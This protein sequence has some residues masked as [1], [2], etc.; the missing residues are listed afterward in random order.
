MPSLHISSLIRPQRTNSPEHPG[1]KLGNTGSP[2]SAPMPSYAMYGNTSTPAIPMDQIPALNPPAAIPTQGFFF[3]REDVEEDND[4]NNNFK[5][6]SDW[7]VSRILAYDRVRE[8]RLYDEAMYSLRVIR[9]FI[10][11]TVPVGWVTYQGVFGR[12]PLGLL[13]S[14]SERVAVSRVNRRNWVMQGA[15]GRAGGGGGSGGSA[16]F[17]AGIGTVGAAA[18]GFGGAGTGTVGTS[19][20]TDNDG[21]HYE[22]PM[23]GYWN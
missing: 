9:A 16:G 3:T 10:L 2:K 15:Q 8:W 21:F 11:A 5:V 22:F 13:G 14:L 23:Q 4:N 7:A 1:L 12:G 19:S 18:G 20:T 6:A 17:G